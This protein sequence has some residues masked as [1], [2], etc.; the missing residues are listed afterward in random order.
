MVL[1]AQ[2]KLI[3]EVKS[4]LLINP[5]AS[6]VPVYSPVNIIVR[7]ILDPVKHSLF[8]PECFLNR[9][10]QLPAVV[11]P[12]KSDFIRIVGKVF[13]QLSVPKMDVKSC[14]I[15]TRTEKE[16]DIPGIVP[17]AE[18]KLTGEFECI[19]E[20]ERS[21][22]A[23]RTSAYPV[24]KLVCGNKTQSGGFHNVLLETENRIVSRVKAR[25]FIRFCLCAQGRELIPPSL[26]INLRSSVDIG[27][28]P[29]IEQPDSLLVNLGL[30]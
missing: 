5:P 12:D 10:I 22:N 6:Q 23:G 15:V 13:P 24:H 25:R 21:V 27:N 4:Q 9:R 26:P 8:H 28:S 29:R 20:V 3:P 16:G 14:R 17:V 1:S 11:V 19:C 7:I 18:C 30:F 2:R